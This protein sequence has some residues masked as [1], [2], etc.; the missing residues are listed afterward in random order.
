MKWL[1][2][3]KNELFLILFCFLCAVFLWLF[4]MRS[5]DSALAHR[6]APEILRFHVIG[7]SNSPRDQ[8]IKLRVKSFLLEQIERTSDNTTQQQKIPDTINPTPTKD[9]LKTWLLI[10]KEDLENHTET[11]I[12]SLGETY[13]VSLEITWTEFPE[14]TYGDLRLPAG[15]YETAQITLGKGRGHNWWCMLY[16]KVCITKDTITTIPESS[17]EELNQLLSQ[18]DCQKLH[19][20]SPP[21]PSLPRIRLSLRSVELLKTWMQKSA[22]TKYNPKNPATTKNNTKTTKNPSPKTTTP[23]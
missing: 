9:T 23:K 17:W 14:K 2:S 20:T 4:Q 7:N 6:I 10:H 16:P 5:E 22:T 12:R 11:Y 8:E 13:P 19:L 18:E 15:T 1:K 21:P 3:E